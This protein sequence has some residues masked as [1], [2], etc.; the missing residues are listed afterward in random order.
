MDVS[1][2]T[3]RVVEPETPRV[4]LMV[5]E[6]AVTAV[7]FPC[8]PEAL[9]MVAT[10]LFEELQATSVVKSW[11]EPSENVPAAVNC[12]VEP[13]TALGPAGVTAMDEGPCTAR[14]VVPETAPKVALMVVEPSAVEEASPPEL[15]VATAVLDEFQVTS[16]VISRMTAF[17]NVPLAEN[18]WVVPAA[19]A[20]FAGVTA[21]DI[22]VAESRGVEPETPPKVALIV[23]VPAATAVATPLEAIVTAAVLDE[24]QVA[25]AVR[26]WVALFDKTPVALNC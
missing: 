13:T 1:A 10:A 16:G 18:C 20:G 11:T 19:I 23:L 9:L 22:T 15:M 8:E 5:A 12:W 4:A 21:M 6:P 17:D 3:V 2:F 14:E 26:S 25:T 24:S 7:A